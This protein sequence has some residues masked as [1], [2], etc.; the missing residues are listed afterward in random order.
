MED[1]RPS[2]KTNWLDLSIAGFVFTILLLFTYAFFVKLPYL[3][4]EIS[5]NDQTITWINPN[6]LS[7]NRL[8]LGDK[9]LL[10]GEIDLQEIYEKIYQSPYENLYEGS[11]VNLVIQRLDETTTVQWVFPGPT[12]SEFIRRFVSFWYLSFI[13]WAFGLATALLVRPRDDRWLF[14]VA[15]DYLMALW[16]IIGANS[17]GRIWYSGVLMRS[18][19]WL[20]LPVSLALHWTFPSRIKPPKPIFRS[21]LFTTGLVLAIFE[22][23]RLLP[24]NVYIIAL[25]ISV[26][27]SLTL[28]IYQWITLPTRRSEVGLP[29]IILGIFFIVALETTISSYIGLSSLRSEITLL[30]FPLLPMSYFYTIYAST[31]SGMEIRINR[32]ISNLVF[33]SFLIL[34][35]L[36]FFTAINLWFV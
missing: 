9:I 35:T 31:V 26:F 30:F 7:P 20:L 36:P 21:V 4:I 16:I 5:L 23:F 19:S 1:R 15:F 13:F 6:N 22:L 17:E 3:G 10:F 28:L 14:M 29:L 12:V 8:L 2:F 34:P 33:F 27:G 32:W 18:L 25:F 24:T 11:I